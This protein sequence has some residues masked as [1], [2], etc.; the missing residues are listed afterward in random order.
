MARAR[1]KE[2]WRNFERDKTVSTIYLYNPFRFSLTIGYLCRKSDQA[3]L[4]VES[5]DF[6]L[7]QHGEHQI[8][9]KDYGFTFEAGKFF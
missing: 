7:Y 9:P 3:V 1:L 8:L 4:P 5:S 2:L 6:H